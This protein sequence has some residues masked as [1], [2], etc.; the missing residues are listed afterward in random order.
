MR[1]GVRAKNASVSVCV[2]APS[3]RLRKRVTARL[4]GG[5]LQETSRERWIVRNAKCQGRIL[6]V[7]ILAPK[8]LNSGLKIAVDFWMDF[9]PPVFSKEKGTAK[10][11]RE[12]VQ[13]NSRRI[14][15]EAFS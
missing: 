8:L 13:K 9:C 7:W 3:K 10:F 14:S 2:S 12:F 4:P 11:T 6:A 5:T 1:V 15:A